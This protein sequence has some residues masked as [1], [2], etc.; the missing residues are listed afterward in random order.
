M[1][2]QLN[3]ESG[4][5]KGK[6][7]PIPIG[8]RVTVGYGSGSDIVLRDKNTTT[9]TQVT[10]DFINKQLTI[11]C[12]GTDINLVVN[13]ETTNQAILSD[14]DWLLID[15]THFTV[16][17][18]TSHL[19]QS[20][21][22]AEDYLHHHQPLYGILDAAC[23]PHILSALRYSTAQYQSLFNGQ[24]AI[25]LESYAPYLVQLSENE[26]LLNEWLNNDFNHTWGIWLSCEEPFELMRHHLRKFL[27]ITA[28]GYQ[29]LYFRYYDPRVLPQYLST[30][31]PKDLK[32]FFGPISSF[33]CKTSKSN[34]LQQYQIKN[35]KL[36]TDEITLTQPKL[37][38]AA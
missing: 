22:S 30:C 13:G 38:V 21:C 15:Y 28:S 23:D 2:T 6:T 11:N 27:W 37:E 24:I 7:I 9:H 12:S 19:L 5:D 31:N 20:P 26:S 25:E 1:N 32:K 33:F 3:I 34:N 10:F 29:E 4:I 35:N 16:H 18:H 8:S 17:L 14:Q 36:F